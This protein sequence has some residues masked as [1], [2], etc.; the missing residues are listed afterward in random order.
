MTSGEDAPAPQL[1][2]VPP[3]CYRTS[4]GGNLEDAVVPRVRGAVLDVLW[5]WR[6]PLSPAKVS[7]NSVSRAPEGTVPLGAEADVVPARGQ[8]GVEGK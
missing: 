5:S 4:T 8:D 7:A 1:L 3:S 2:P 6:R